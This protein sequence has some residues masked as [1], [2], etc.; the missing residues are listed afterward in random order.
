[1]NEFVIDFV[2]HSTIQSQALADLIADYT[3]SPLEPISIDDE[4]V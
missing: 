4:V 3:P 2:Y 1:L